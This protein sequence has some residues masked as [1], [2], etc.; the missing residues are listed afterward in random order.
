MEIKTLTSLDIPQVVQLARQN[1]FECI[2]P[3]LNDV[4]MMQA[5]YEY[6]DENH[7]TQLMNQRQLYI[8]GA[9]E[10]GQLVGVAGM[11]AE[12]HITMLYVQKMYQR[13][14]IGKELLYTM[15][16]FSSSELHHKKITVS[17]MPA[18][19]WTFFQ[20]NGFQKMNNVN[21]MMASFVPME[22]KSV[23]VLTYEKQPLKE[24]SILTIVG[25]FLTLCTFV[26]VAV[27][28]KIVFGGAI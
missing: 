25:V 27:A 9:Y 3:F 2:K 26:A 15:R 14:G 18:W 19:S 28:W 21:T 4:G 23:S 13:R 11:Q 17:A 20:K 24:S 7:L 12:G 22:A 8:W 6:V 10:N 5:F 1:F 16:Q